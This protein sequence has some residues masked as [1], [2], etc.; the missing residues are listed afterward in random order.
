MERTLPNGMVLRPAAPSDAEYISGCIRESVLLSVPEEQ[1][2]LSNLWIDTIVSVSMREISERRMED[3]V[4]V[5]TDDSDRAGMLWLGSSN[6]QFTCDPT[7][8]LLG[9]YVEPELRRQGIGSML[10]EEAEAICREKG[11][12][13]MTLNVGAPNSAAVSFYDKHG[14]STQTFVKQKV[15][16]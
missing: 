2:I 16:R 11:Y 15:L 7:G 14:F 8:Y 1:R 10:L 12:I 13:T 9:I 3:D 5:L 6:D 4:M